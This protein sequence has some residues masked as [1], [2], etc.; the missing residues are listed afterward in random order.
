MTQPT[1]PPGRVAGQ[2]GTR[3]RG[4]ARE[5]GPWVTWLGRLGFACKGAVYLLVGVL[6]LQAALGAGGATTDPQGVL[7][8][9][10]EAP[11]GRPLLG[12]VA[13]GLAGYVLWRLV[14]ALLD[15][16]GKGTEPK[17]LW[18][19]GG[20]LVSAA[21]YTTL[22][23]SALR[24]LQ[25][26][27]GGRGGDQAAQDWTA[28][29]L[30]Q[31]LGQWLVAAAG[32]IVIGTACVQFY[33]AYKA[34]FRDALRLDEMSATQVTWVTR[35]GRLGFAARGVV[36]GV[37]GGFL[38]LAAFSAQPGEAR[39]LSGALATLAAQPFGPWLLGV[40]ALGL[41]AYGVFELIEARYH[42]IVIT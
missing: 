12:L 23:L 19:R 27:G 18:A 14:Q 22:A 17:G 29:L 9:I 33:K 10:V 34:S 3:A 30:S 31:P 41:I 6:A 20:Y 16:E 7:G 35:V 13:L 42:R 15:T 26:T 11:Y 25:G 8:R 40:V 1:F 2:V 28:R 21:A 4:A 32:A 38:I 24:L 37:V 36:F 39:G 5:A